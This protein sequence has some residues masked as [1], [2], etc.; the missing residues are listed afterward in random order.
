MVIF[1]IGVVVAILVA[2]AYIG[3]G[4]VD[5]LRIRMELR[6][7]AARTGQATGEDGP[8]EDAEALDAGRETVGFAWRAVGGVVASVGL[9]YA[10]SHLW[11]SWYALPALALGTGVAV[12]V[13]FVIDPT[14]TS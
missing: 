4:T 14:R 2:T 7:T 13:A 10:V 5:F 9:L 12:S 3:L 6:Q 11:W 8:M 1:V